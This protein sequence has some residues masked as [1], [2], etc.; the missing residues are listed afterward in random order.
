[1]VLYVFCHTSYG[2][3]Y[4]AIVV[5]KFAFEVDDIDWSQPPEAAV[6]ESEVSSTLFCLLQLSLARIKRSIPIPS[7]SEN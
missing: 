7:D 4:I 6:T 2:L 1:M 5:W 3:Y